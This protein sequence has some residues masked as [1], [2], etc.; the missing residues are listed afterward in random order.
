MKRWNN[1]SGTLNSRINKI[2]E[3]APKLA[4][5]NNHFSL[6]ELSEK[7]NSLIVICGNLHPFAVKLSLQKWKQ[8]MLLLR[9]NSSHIMHQKVKTSDC[10]VLL[11]YLVY[12]I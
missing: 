10:G 4:Y 7:W 5:K 8:T 6:K 9:S 1:Y 12:T 2:F 11:K 3:V